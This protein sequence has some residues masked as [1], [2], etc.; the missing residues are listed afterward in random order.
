MRRPGDDRLLVRGKRGHAPR[1]VLAV[2][3]RHDRRRHRPADRFRAREPEG[4]FRGGVELEHRAR[5]IDRDDAIESRLDRGAECLLG[6]RLLPAQASALQR[7]PHHLR[8]TRRAILRD[9]IGRSGLDHLD[10]AVFAD[11][12]GEDDE[13]RVVAIA[14]TR[15][16]QCLRSAKPWHGVISDDDVWIER[17]RAD[18]SL[19]MGDDLKI[20]DDPGVLQFRFAQGCVGRT[21][22]EHEDA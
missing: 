19:A 11:R 21:V 15:H 10:G 8:E 3:R 18:E 2:T 4:P 22:L 20:R 5:F 7:L 16:L 14:G 12:A 17:E 9:E 6:G 1:V 13:W